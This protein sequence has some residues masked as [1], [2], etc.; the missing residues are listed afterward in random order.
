MRIA[1]TFNEK[2]SDTEHDAEYDSMETILAL[3]RTLASM[4]HV[5]TPVEVSGA[6]DGVIGELRR[7]APELVFNLAEGTGGRFREAFYPALL[8]QLGLPHTGSG[9]SALAL[10][11]DKA[12]AKRVVAAARVPTPLARLVRSLPELDAVAARGEIALPVIVKPN[13]EGTSKG[14]TQASV[15]TDA[16]ALEGVVAEL[17]ARY[18]AGVLVEQYIDGIDVAVGWVDG[19]GV[20]PPIGYAYEPTGEHAIYD[21]ALKQG[22][23]ERID[24]QVPARLDTVTTQRLLVLARRAF[25]ALGI[26]GYGRA[27]FRV[28][29]D[30]GV[31][32]L[33]MNPLPT[34][35]P[36][37]RDLYAAAAAIGKSPRDL[38]GA[39]VDA[40]GTHRDTSSLRPLG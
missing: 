22:P 14:I 18:P 24:V 9:A 32:F 7:V 33:E 35:D 13:F 3:A 27:D 10:S 4:G 12:L 6:V 19:L 36:R 21:L 25:E 29:P 37:E 31:Y 39:I 28:T 5:V 2:R 8:E 38:L 11:M 34:L 40:S 17:L 1:L 23:P 26:A 16:A 20:L 30:G 15:V